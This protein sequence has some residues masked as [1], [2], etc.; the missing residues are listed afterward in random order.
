MR[1]IPLTQNKYAIVDDK[2]YEELSKYKWYCCYAPHKKT[3]YAVTPIKIGGKWKSV[4]MHRL[5]L[6]APKGKFT[7]HKNG[8]GYDNRRINIRICTNA[9]NQHNQYNLRTV[10]TS[11]YKGVCH[12]K[13][14]KI[15]R[16][17]IVVAQKQIFLG[18]F[19]SEIEAA[20]AYDKAAVKYF[21][22]FAHCNF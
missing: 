14:Y 5:I 20:M 15:W 21:G 2:D 7:D 18:D 16:A 10:K 1:F 3:Y 17:Q 9:E 6:N 11:K 12:R 8:R 13:S 19:S 22:E 4:S